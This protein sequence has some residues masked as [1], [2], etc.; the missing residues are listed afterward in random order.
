MI[1]FLQKDTRFMKALFWVIISVACITM[2]IFLVPGLF[3]DQSAAAD[4][5]ATIG[6]GGFFGHF[7]PASDTIPATDV[8][9]LAQRM[10]QR[11]QLPDF[12][13]PFMMQRVGE[14]LIQQRLELIEAKHLGITATDDDVRNFL[15]TGQWG[16]LLFPDGKYIGDAQYAEFVSEQFQMTREKFEN[17]IKHEIIENRLRALVTGGVTI[18]DN[19]VRSAYTDQATK[20]KFDYA[21]L[22]SDTLRNQ[23]NPSD[24]E[25]QAYFKQNAAKYAHAVPE[26]RKLQYIAFTVANLPSPPAPVTDAEVQQYYQ[27]HLKTYQVDEQVKVR[28]I[29][30]A[31]NGQDPKADA[32][33]KA[34]A[35]GILDQLH[36][37]ADFAKLAKE[38]SD[39]PGSKSQGGELGWIKHGVTVAEFDQSAFS[40]SPGQI[41]GLVRS[42]F[43][44]HIIQTEEKQPAHTRPLDEVKSE[45]TAT[46]TRQN[47]SQ[48]EQAFAQQ[49]SSEAAKSGLAATAA[50]H[51]LQVVNT[52]Y[53]SQSAVVPNVADG[54]Q[55]LTGAFAAKQNAAPQIASTGDGYAVYQ[56]AGIQPAH[57][58]DFASWK[59]HVL[60]D[61]RDQ[62][63]PQLLT[64]KTDELAAKAR[65]GNDLAKAAKQVGATV[66]SSDLVGRD[67]Q[68][69]DIGALSTAA[70]QLFTMS[71]GQVSGPI[72]TGHTGIVAK[73]TDK[74]QPTSED[75][76]KNLDSTRDAMLAQRRDEMF[77][78]FVSN[79]QNVYQK[80]G[81]IRINR[82][83][84]QQ[85]G[86]LGGNPQS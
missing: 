16:A 68:V 34:K 26:A 29:L 1:R 23:I 28:H 44:Y 12:A 10:L 20:I 73:I 60:D 86:P 54:S 62:Q 42:K 63:L 58:P 2:V 76:A 71:V 3:N 67:A 79:L 52:D 85:Q 55:L 40:L 77:E 9:N 65:A 84:Q 80:D 69:P 59:S 39:D 41:S 32:A 6:H 11:Q 37:G 21:V 46:L 30:I 45:I 15:H 27:Q 51:H 38:N 56:V 49:L 22:D 17:E 57:A 4:T 43:G 82:K 47:E 25:L 66:K 19:E 72:N 75:V 33:A 53:L 13:L 8:Q 50:A 18:S 24:T 31:V 14:G 35:Q 64:E 83:A 61:Y 78:V 81:R 70:P 5:Y 36:H 7:L 48:A 74:Q